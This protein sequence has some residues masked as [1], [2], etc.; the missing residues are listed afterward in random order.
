MDKQFSTLGLLCMRWDHIEAWIEELKNV[1]TILENMRKGY[2]PAASYTYISLTY[3]AYIH[4][5]S[6]ADLQPSYKSI[7]NI[8]KWKGFDINKTVDLTIKSLDIIYRFVI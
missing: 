3:S 4:K 8:N 6:L 5:K 7:L 2:N 1:I